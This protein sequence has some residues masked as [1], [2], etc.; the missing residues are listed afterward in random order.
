[1]LVEVIKVTVEHVHKAKCS[2]CEKPVMIKGLKDQ[3][4]LLTTQL[5]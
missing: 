2:G 1:L 3:C 4:M 5:L